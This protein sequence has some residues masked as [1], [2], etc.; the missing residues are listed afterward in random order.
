MQAEMVKLKAELRRTT[1]ERDILKKAAAYLAQIK[2]VHGYKRPRSKW[3][4]GSYPVYAAPPAINPIPASLLNVASGRYTVALTTS[5]STAYTL[6]ATRAD[7]Q[8][9]DAC[10]DFVLDQAN[11]RTTTNRTAAQIAVI[12]DN[13]CWSR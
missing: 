6:L 3:A 1:E 10:G 7:S 5:S 11:A 2:S 12:S 8:I 4:T 9:G 13:D